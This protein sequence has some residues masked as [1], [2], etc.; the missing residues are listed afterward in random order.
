MPLPAAH[1]LI[2]ATVLSVIRKDLELRR[3]WPA[4]LIGAAIGILPDLDLILVWG[5]GYP[6]KLHGSFTHSIVFAIAFGSAIS[7]LLKE[8]SIRGVLAYIGALLSHGLMD[9]ATKKE[10]GGAQLLWPFTDQKY[11]MGLFSNYEFYPNPPTQSYIEILK[12]GSV[13][14]FYEIAAFLPLLIL[15]LFLKTRPWKRRNADAADEGLTNNG[16]N[17]DIK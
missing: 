10:F 7:I 3:D 6:M 4:I 9:V 14:S 2:G 8:S 11:R 15:I 16:N 12:Q 13:L 1:G 17:N 5:L